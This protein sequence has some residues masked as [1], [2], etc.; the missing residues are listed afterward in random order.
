MVVLMVVFRHIVMIALFMVVHWS[1]AFRT[2]RC[3]NCRW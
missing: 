2:G 3:E 1:L